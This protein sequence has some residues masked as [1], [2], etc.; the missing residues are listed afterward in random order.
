M[1]AVKP[2]VVVVVIVHHH[3]ALPLPHRL[4]QAFQQT[5]ADIRFHDEPVDDQ[6]NV[7]DLITIE[8]QPRENF[9]D[10]AVDPGIQIAFFSQSFEQ[11]PVMSFATAHQR[12]Q[13]G[14]FPTVEVPKDQ[15]ADLIVG[16]VYHLF[17]RYRRIGIRRT[18]EQQP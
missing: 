12:S 1:P 8:S 4:L 13:Q 5:A 7:V 18:G 10:F 9:S 6:F 3:R 17:A 16:M 15:I 2:D 14:D 11:F